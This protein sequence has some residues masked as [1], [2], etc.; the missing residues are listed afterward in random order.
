MVVEALH[1]SVVLTFEKS[2]FRKNEPRSNKD[3]WVYS[4]LS[5]HL[6]LL[7]AGPSPLG[8]HLLALGPQFKKIKLYSLCCEVSSITILIIAFAIIVI[9]TIIP[10]AGIDLLGV[11]NKS[12]KEG[13]NLFK[14]NNKDVRATSLASF[15]YLYC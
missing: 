3:S 11:N 8:P 7:A 5:L 13:V 15:K 2:T 10:A 6:R 4:A 9:A 1:N 14:A 12:L